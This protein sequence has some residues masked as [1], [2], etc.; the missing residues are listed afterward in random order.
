MMENQYS[1]EHDKFH[2]IR[3]P[4]WTGSRL[5]KVCM[6]SGAEERRQ[7]QAVLVPN[8]AFNSRRLMPLPLFSL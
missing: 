4:V 7:D 8:A 6:N 1:T 5:V 2:I 3:P